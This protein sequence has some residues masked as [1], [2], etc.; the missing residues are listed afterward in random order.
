[1]SLGLKIGLSI[2]GGF[3]FIVLALGLLGAIQEDR[4]TERPEPFVCK[5]CD[6]FIK[7]VESGVITNTNGVPA[8]PPGS[9]GNS[10]GSDPSRKSTQRFD[11]HRSDDC[12]NTYDMRR[13]RC[14]E[15][16]R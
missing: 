9:I 6:Q 10:S 1:M 12:S 2:S 5:P 8:P 16:L 3:L 14:A 13:A 11:R 4:N 15:R 7:D